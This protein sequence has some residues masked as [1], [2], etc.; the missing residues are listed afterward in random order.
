M[1]LVQKYLEIHTFGDLAKNHGVYASFSKSGHKFSLNYDMIEAKDSD[2]LSQECR[3]LILAANDY[4]TFLS[5][6]IQVNNKLNFDHICPGKTKIIAYGLKRFFN[7]GTG[8]CAEVDWN[9]PKLSILSKLDGTL[10]I[11]GFCPISNEWHIATRS[12]PEADVLLDNGLFTFRTLF[13]KACLETTGLTFEQFT[14]QLCKNITY[15]FELT[16]L[17]N[18]VVCYYPKN[19]ITLLAARDIT[20]LQELDINTLKLPSNTPI[21]RSYAYTSVQEIVE[22]V[23]TLSPIDHEGVV[24]LDSN[25]NR[26][27]IKSAQYL[28]FNKLH[29]SLKTSER[30]IIEIILHEKDDDVIAF[31][32]EEIAKNLTKLK[33]GLQTTLKHHDETYLAAKSQAEA[34]QPG[35]KK[36]FAIL[37]T[38]DKTLWTAPFFQIYDEKC[39]NMREFILNNKKDGTWSTSFLDK[40][41][42]LAKSA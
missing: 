40:L 13:E 28:A 6:A 29:D 24:V 41:L 25:F 32:P 27:K 37:I 4:R 30:N 2:L 33:F 1:L 20:T 5:E 10:T 11:C 8:S 18:R 16:S 23:S 22:W 34:I 39:A 15:C 21:V 3:G 38:K 26:V 9:D 7:Y 31:L 19:T 12:R 42:E 35:D 14:N 17:L 36:T